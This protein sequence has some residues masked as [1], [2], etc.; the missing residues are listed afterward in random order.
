MWKT[1]LLFAGCFI[2]LNILFL[3]FWVCVY[4]M[5]TSVGSPF[6]YFQF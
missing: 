2:A 1:L 3:L 5:A 4:V 6:L